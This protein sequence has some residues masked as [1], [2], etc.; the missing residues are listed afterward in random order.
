M[1]RHRTQGASLLEMLFAVVCCAPITVGWHVLYT[2]EY[3]KGIQ[4]WEE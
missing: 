4:Q 3:E 1:P 2:D